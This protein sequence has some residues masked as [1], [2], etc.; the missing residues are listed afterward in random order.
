MRLDN[1]YI[2]VFTLSF[3]TWQFFRGAREKKLKEKIEKT[4]A[5]DETI[6]KM[7]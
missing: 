7:T 2:Y 1:I 5:L 3:H 6:V 4:E